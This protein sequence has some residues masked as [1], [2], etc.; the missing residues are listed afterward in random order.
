MTTQQ[1]RDEWNELVLEIMML[2]FAVDRMTPYAVFCEYSGHVEQLSI[3]IVK[4]K[5]NWQ[6]EIAASEFYLDGRLT[7]ANDIHAFYKK[8]RDLLKAI[9]AEGE[10]DYSRFEQVRTEVIDYAF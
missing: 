3:K 2:A 7:Y 1:E 8:K 4:S 5:D 10:V 6:S 9:L